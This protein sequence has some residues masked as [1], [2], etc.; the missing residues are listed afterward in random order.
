[1]LLLSLLW[2]L[3]LSVS[4]LLNIFFHFLFT[5]SD[6]INFRQMT[7]HNNK[8]V[9]KMDISKTNISKHTKGTASLR[10]VSKLISNLNW[11]QVWPAESSQSPCSCFTLIHCWSIWDYVEVWGIKSSTQQINLGKWLRLSKFPQILFWGRLRTAAENYKLMQNYNLS[12]DTMHKLKKQFS[13]MCADSRAAAWR[14]YLLTY[15][16]Y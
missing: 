3:L 12:V 15:V 10:K 8:N 13:N 4:S 7:R 16:Q 5:C 6:S 14:T 1:M 9:H 11:D 2:P